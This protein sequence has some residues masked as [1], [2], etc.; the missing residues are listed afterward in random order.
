MDQI[1]NKSRKR[2]TKNPCL[3]CGLSKDF[4]ICSLIPVLQTRTRV[5]LVVHRKELKRTTNT[6]RLAIKSLVNSRMY[7]RG[8]LD[9]KSLDLSDLISADYRSVLFYPSDDAVELNLDFMQQNPLPIQLIVPDGNWR[10]ASKV[11]SRHPE[12][13]DLEKV[14][15]SSAN[16][17]ENHLRKEHFAEGMSTLQAIALALGVTEG[18]DVMEALMQVYNLKLKRTLQGR[19]VKDA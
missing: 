4:C 2:K 13:A 14:K 5:C 15:I 17:A 12:L 1:L 16:L 19:G 6:G 10:Q 18:A 9:Q 8:E 3:D 11:Y 7:I